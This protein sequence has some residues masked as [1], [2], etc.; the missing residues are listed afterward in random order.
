MVRIHESLKDESVNQ[1]KLT[2]S[3][4]V[5]AEVARWQQTA[6]ESEATFQ[7]RRS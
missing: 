1:G 7:A 5:P 6:P 3:L 2:S 4:I